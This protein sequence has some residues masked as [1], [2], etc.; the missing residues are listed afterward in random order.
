MTSG[1]SHR[2]RLLAVAVALLVGPAPAVLAQEAPASAVTKPPAANWASSCSAPS[3][4]A[5]LSCTLEQRVVLRETGQQ[6]ARIA[7]QTSGPEPRTPGLLVHLPLGL[8]IAAGVSL[9]VDG[10]SPRKLPVQT[11]DAN[12][13]YAGSTLDPDL[14]TALQRGRDLTLTFE[15]LQRKPIS[16]GFRLDGFSAAFANIK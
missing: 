7:V 12:G 15:D 4:T 10:A 9:S 16:V 6:L 3:R 8:S 2:L 1:L 11:C 13:C 5:P 14:L